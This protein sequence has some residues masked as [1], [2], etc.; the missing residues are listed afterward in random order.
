MWW[1]SSLAR[2]QS[3]DNPY[4]ALQTV[5]TKKWATAV[6]DVLMLKQLIPASCHEEFSF[7]FPLLGPTSSA[8]LMPGADAPGTAWSLSS[9]SLEFANLLTLSVFILAVISSHFEALRYSL[10][11]LMCC[12]GPLFSITLLCVHKCNQCAAAWPSLHPFPPSFTKHPADL[13]AVRCA[14]QNKCWVFWV[15][16]LWHTFKQSSRYSQVGGGKFR[17]RVPAA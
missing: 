3:R 14:S 1:T 4:R 5:P 8:V 15:W 9:L 10:T 13:Q 16:T 12:G 11:P 2:E 17:R 6:V 7:S